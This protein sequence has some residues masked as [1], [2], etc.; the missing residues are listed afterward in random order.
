MPTLLAALLLALQPASPPAVAAAPAKPF[1]RAHRAPDCRAWAQVRT[2]R[3]GLPLLEAAYNLWFHGYVTGFNAHGPDPAGDLLGPATWKQL[4][5]FIDDYCARNPSHLVADALEP[6][7]V[8]LIGRRPVP[9]SPARRG[10]AR[11]A[12]MTVDT[13]CAEWTRARNDQLMRT[14]YGGA[15][16]GYLTAYN[17]WG[18]DPSGDALGPG[19]DALIDPWIDKWCRGQSRAGLIQAV[20]P[21]IAHL[22]ARRAAGRLPPGKTKAIDPLIP[23]DPG[24][25]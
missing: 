4:G 19:N 1:Y 23:T 3:G 18:P 6:L 10:A 25:R 13:T 8:D 9:A 24:R 16:R 5:A 12:T 2:G 17:R 15:V 7:A 21:F 20:A 22:A 11:L 14:Y